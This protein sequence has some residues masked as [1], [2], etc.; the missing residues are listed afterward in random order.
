MA[1]D[2][3]SMVAAGNTGPEGDG[4]RASNSEMASLAE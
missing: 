2:T 4:V 1:E 3:D